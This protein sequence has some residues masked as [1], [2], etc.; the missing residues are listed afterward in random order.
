MKGEDKVF[1]TKITEMTGIEYPVIEGGMMFIGVA[2]LAAA[3]SNAGGLGSISANMHLSKEDL[4]N[5]IRRVRSLTEKPFAV[6]ISMLPVESPNDMTDTYVEAVIEEKVP[7]VETSG[8]SPE[9]FLRRLQ[10]NGIKVFHKVPAGRPAEQ[11]AVKA[12]QIGVDAV[13]VAGFDCG[14]HPGI[15]K[16]SSLIFVRKAVRAVKIPVIAAGGFCDAEG[17][18][19]A[20]A[21]GAEA[22]T[23]GTRFVMT[24][25]CI[26]HPN[27]KERLLKAQE[28]DTMLVQQSIKNTVRVLANAAADRALGMEARE[29][30]IEELLSVIRG[31]GK[32]SWAEGDVDFGMIACGTVIGLIDRVIPAGDVVA[33]IISGAKQI[34][35]RL[36]RIIG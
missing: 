2:E 31:R 14:G 25:E 9:K 29:A 24:K 7:V 4:K 26:A 22:V 5:E 8:R 17:F 27:I 15:N 34:R 30:G 21:L 35:E 36:N 16:V 19:A 13:I 28:Y 12:E 18:V 32:V 6:T 1:K 33:E 10:E 3:V 20:L 23:M 11:Y